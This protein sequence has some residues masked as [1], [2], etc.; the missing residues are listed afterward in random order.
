[1]KKTN[2]NEE[3]LTDNLNNHNEDESP[4]TEPK[5]ESVNKKIEITEGEEKEEKEEKK[6]DSF[7]SKRGGKE[8]K[9]KEEVEKLTL[10]KEEL[11]DKF[12]RLFSEFDNYKKR[13]N[14]EKIDIINTASEKVIL[15]L[16]PIIDDFERAIEY[17][18]ETGEIEVVKEGF[19]LIYNKLSALMKRMG[20]AEIAAQDQV[21]DTDYHEAVTHFPA[22]SD[23][24]KGK[25]M[26]VVEKGYTLND[27]VIRFSKV[28]VAN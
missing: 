26:D 3:E 22:T 7:F 19:E 2:H 10:E 9:L 25:V 8:K 17:N 18:K 12:L 27:K 20:V 5:E 6:A 16:L 13:T 24:Q 4:A 28:V 23:D 15:G 14:K 11:N 1:M 21:F